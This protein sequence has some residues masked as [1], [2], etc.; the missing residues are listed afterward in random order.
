MKYSYY[1]LRFFMEII[2][3]L[4]FW[5]YFTLGFC[6]FLF[7]VYFSGFLVMR[8]PEMLF[9]RLNHNF[10]RLFFTLSR[11]FIPGL[12]ITIPDEVKNI[13]S[14][15]II[16]NHVSYIDPILLISLYPMQ[17]TIVKRS[18]YAMPL[19]GWFLKNSGYISYSAN[20]S[21]SLAMIDLIQDL[22][23]Y[24]ARGGN[25]FVFPEGTRMT[26][27][28]IGKF[29]KGAFSLARRCDAPIVL[30]Q[31]TNTDRLIK[32][33]NLWYSTCFKNPVSI[34]LLKVIKPDYASESFSLKSLIA[35]ARTSYVSA[36]P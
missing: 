27:G 17:K 26:G 9:Q 29:H 13:R 36:R 33:G 35:E 8:N 3:N 31:I 2:I 5:L 18:I 34:R 23:N 30:L 32:P 4:F 28:E 25:L 21:N 6:L 12:S 10:Y 19:F 11:I 16:C 14:S 15:V 24:L 20:D 1:P 22:R 7:P